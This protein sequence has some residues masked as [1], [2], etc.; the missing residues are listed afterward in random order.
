MLPPQ[1]KAGTLFDEILVT[2]S[3]KEAKAFAEQ[4]WAAKKDNEKKEY[5]KFKTKQKAEEKVGVSES[6]P[7]SS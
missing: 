5:E 1:V 2:D 3:L 7:A 4:T 6:I